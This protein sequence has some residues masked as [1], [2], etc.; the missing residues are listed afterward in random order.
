M[1]HGYSLKFLV[2]LAL[3]VLNPLV[4]WAGIAVGAYLA[5][6]TARR[7]YYGLGTG[8]YMVSWGM[9]LAGIALAGPEGIALA[10]K[11]EHVNVWYMLPVLFVLLVGV[12]L[13]VWKRTA[14]IPAPQKA[15][16]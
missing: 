14:T 3:L 1:I 15:E 11:Y 5:R 7:Y 6:R 4:G 10:K 2:G 16:E 9:A 12:G 13:Y 8:M